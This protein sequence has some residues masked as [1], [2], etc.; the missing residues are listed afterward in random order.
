MTE[1][2]KK[3]AIRFDALVTCQYWPQGTSLWTTTRASLQSLEFH[4]DLQY[5]FIFENVEKKRLGVLWTVSSLG[6]PKR[7]LS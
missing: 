7:R 2:Y 5:E 6:Q 1:G 3:K 4:P